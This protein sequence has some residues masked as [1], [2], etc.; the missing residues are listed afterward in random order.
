MANQKSFLNRLKSAFGIGSKSKKVTGKSIGSAVKGA[1]SAKREGQGIAQDK[2]SKKVRGALS[3]L[4]LYKGQHSAKIGKASEETLLGAMQRGYGKKSIGSAI[5]E[6]TRKQQR[7]I[8]KQAKKALKDSGIDTAKSLQSSALGKEQ[9]KI[10]YSATVRI[11]DELPYEQREQAILNYFG[12]DTM[13]EA[14]N[15]AM[16]DDSIREA[17]E[18]AKQEPEGDKMGSPTYSQMINAIYSY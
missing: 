17:Y 14:W 4:G 3:K 15:M 8:E 2:L 10:L 16:G 11:W 9:Q 18:V 12:V 13:L 1:A 6:S 5:K 7:V